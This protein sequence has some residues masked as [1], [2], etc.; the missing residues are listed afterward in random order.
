MWWKFHFA[1]IQILINESLQNLAHGTTG[2][3]VACAKFCVDIISSNLIRAKWNFQRILIVIEKSLVKWVPGA[4]AAHW[5]A[6]LLSV[7]PMLSAPYEQVFLTLVKMCVSTLLRFWFHIFYTPTS[8]KGYI[9]FTF[10]ACPSVCLSI[11][12]SLCLSVDKNHVR[13]VSSTIPAR[14][15]SYL[16]IISTKFRRCFEF[17]FKFQNVEFW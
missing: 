17:F 14:S 4:W 16:H 15:I 1:L 8:T 11:C 3:V 9:G 13:S 10:S 7:K 12:L 5:L 2:A 6:Q